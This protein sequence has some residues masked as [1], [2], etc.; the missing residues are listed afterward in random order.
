LTN[1]AGVIQ[2]INVAHF[3]LRHDLLRSNFS[4]A[5]VEVKK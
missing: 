3:L 2:K 5:K 1:A 4:S